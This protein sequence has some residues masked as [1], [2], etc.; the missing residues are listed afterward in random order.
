MAEVFEAHCVDSWV[1]ANW[2]VGGHVKP[3]NQDLLCLTPLRFH[4]RQLHVLQPAKSGIR[5]PYGGTKS[6]GYERGSL[7]KH[8]KLGVMYVGGQ[9]KDR[10]SLHDIE[11]GKRVTQ[12]AKPL[13]CKF[14]TYNNWRNYVPERQYIPNKEAVSMPQA[15]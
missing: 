8:I 12:M 10:L 4:R 5:K 9:M 14:L 7:V 15:L 3:D 2:L 13:D 1:L 11:T 6:Q